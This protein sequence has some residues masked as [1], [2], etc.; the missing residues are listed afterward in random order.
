MFGRL[1]AAAV[2]AG[3]KR[4]ARTMARAVRSVIVRVLIGFWVTALQGSFLTPRLHLRAPLFVEG[5]QFFDDLGMFP[6]DVGGLAD[7]LSE[8]E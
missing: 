6:G 1:G 3:M 7:V 5:G 8:V 4:P 2:A